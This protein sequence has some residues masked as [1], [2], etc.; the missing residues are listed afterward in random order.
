VIDELGNPHELGDPVEIKSIKMESVVLEPDVMV[1]TFNTETGKSYQVISAESVAATTWTA[2][3]IY[4]PTAGGNWG[5]GSEPF[6]AGSTAT[7][8]RIPRNTA[9]AFFKIRKTN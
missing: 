9:K 6:T 3:A 5:Y 1:V 7:T 4:F 8:V 2:T